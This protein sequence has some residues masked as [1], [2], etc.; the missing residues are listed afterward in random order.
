MPICRVWVSD[1]QRGVTSSFRYSDEW[2]A[3]PGVDPVLPQYPL[4]TAT[5]HIAGLFG[6]LED[7]MPDRWGR[8]LVARWFA[9]EG[10]SHPR[11]AD[12]LA[13]VED[14]LRQG[15]LRIVDSDGAYIASGSGVPRIV[16]IPDILTAADEA[17]AAGKSKE[18]LKTLLD[19]GS[20]SV[21]GARPKA[22]V[23]DGDTLWLAKF[24]KTSDD[25]DVI[26]WEAVMAALQGSCNIATAAVKVIATDGRHVLLSKRFDRNGATRVPY[27]SAHAIAALGPDDPGDWAD[28]ADAV[29]A[30]AADVDSG[31]LELFRRLVFDL[32]V[33][34]TDDHLRNH[35][36]IKAD[37]LWRLSPSFDVNPEFDEKAHDL[38]VMGY[39][40]RGG[41]GSECGGLSSFVEYYIPDKAAAVEEGLRV[42]DGLSDWERVAQRLSLP[43]NEISE[44]SS[45][46]REHAVEV[47][48]ALRVIDPAAYDAHVASSH[49]EYLI[50]PHGRLWQIGD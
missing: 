1:T 34:D 41:M 48:S 47:A 8:R 33:N 18:A 44:F 27:M 19:A 12:Y 15:D 21:G 31:E 2:L 46:I 7:V 6:F 13:S 30:V 3:I 23:K 50:A 22:S 11:E 16:D 40:G 35:G 14:S 49:T 38:S 37:G 9:S 39:G 26:G 29:S 4:S 28:V 43:A 32:A 10:K 24:P 5:Y 45:I 36:F 25:H 42:L 17:E 20:S